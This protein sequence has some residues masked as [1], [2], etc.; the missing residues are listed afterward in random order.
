MKNSHERFSLYIL[1]AV[2]STDQCES[3]AIKDA[4]KRKYENE[5]DTHADVGAYHR[6]EA[7]HFLS[8]FQVAVGL[9]F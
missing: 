9:A 8:L 4:I 7:G 2:E 5:D 6:P 1:V 3:V